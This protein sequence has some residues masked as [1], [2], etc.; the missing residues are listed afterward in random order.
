MRRA[1]DRGAPARHGRRHGRARAHRLSR[2]GVS[3]SAIMRNAARLRTAR[4][5]RRRHCSRLVRKATG[6]FYTPQ[7]S[8]TLPVRRMGRRPSRHARSD[9]P[10]AHCPI[11]PEAGVSG[12]RVP[13]SAHAYSA[14]RA[15]HATAG[16]RS[17]RASP[18]GGR[19]ERLYGVDSARWPYWRGFPWRRRWR[20]SAAD[21]RSPVALRRRLLGTWL[22]LRRAD[23]VSP[24]TP[25]RF[26]VGDRP[27]R[28]RC[29]MRHRSG[30]DRDDAER[31]GGRCGRRRVRR[32]DRP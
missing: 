2:S 4:G 24:R 9:P 22:S 7:P 19:C 17:G 10:A 31:Y 18:S 25:W 14:R 26:A 5:A 6:T 23:H 29:A 28:T 13:I 3:S 12:R 15:G 20:R 27:S 8:P 11:R 1:G 30:F 16:R 21:R 32:A